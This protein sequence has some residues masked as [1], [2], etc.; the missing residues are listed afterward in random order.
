M[1]FFTFGEQQE[2]VDNFNKTH[3]CPDLFVNNTDNSFA[4]EFRKLDPLHADTAWKNSV[5]STLVSED[6]K[7]F[8][9]LEKYL[10][11]KNIQSHNKNT[12][13][14]RN[15]IGNRNSHRIR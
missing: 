6:G 3:N 14:R 11:N 4:V 13:I 2:F 5:S 1:S 9:T 10:K 7:K 12:Q 8:F 15:S